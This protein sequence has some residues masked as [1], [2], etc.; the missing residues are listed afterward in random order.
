MGGYNSY[1]ILIDNPS[2]IIPSEKLETNIKKYLWNHKL[3]VVKPNGVITGNG[4]GDGYGNVDVGKKKYNIIYCEEVYG[5]KD[6]FNYY[7]IN[8]DENPNKGLMI[9]DV[10]YKYLKQ[11][12][13][14]NKL[15]LDYNIYDA[16][17][18]FVNSSKRNTGLM[19]KYR[20]YQDIFIQEEDYE[21]ESY[22]QKEFNSFLASKYSAKKKKELGWVKTDKNVWIHIDK[23]IIIENK[24]D[25]ML[26][27]PNIN[28][29]NKNR[30]LKLVDSFI[31]FTL[32]S[33]K[34]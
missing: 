16:L 8:K 19:A 31:K 23:D 30:I 20:N 26:V 21:P 10:V 14:Y 22:T 6:K 11:H 18:N 9:H 1:D 4:N 15:K 33:K 34:K 29:K 2:L 12:K 5:K 28:S 24:N 17:L 32:K 27:D 3:R 25:Y 13:L 7:Y